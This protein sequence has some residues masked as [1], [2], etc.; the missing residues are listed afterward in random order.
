MRPIAGSK[1]IM[2]LSRAGGLVVGLSWFQA[3][4]FQIQVSPKVSPD[5]LFWPPNRSS[6]AVAGSYS[7]VALSRTEGAV[8]GLNWLQLLPSQVQ[9]S[10]NSLKVLAPPKRT[11]LPMRG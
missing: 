6:C 7:K 2:A 1:A 9:V 3:L 8:E 4:P 11:S 5:R 10:F